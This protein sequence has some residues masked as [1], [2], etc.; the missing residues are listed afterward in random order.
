M[1]I[2]YIA[3]IR[4]P[5]ERAH[6]IQ[7]VHMCNA[8]RNAGNTV[9]LFVTT[10]KT[11]ITLDAEEYYGTRFQF[12]VKPLK[13]PDIIGA[14]RY[15]PS[16]LHPYAY[17]LQRF[18]FTREAARAVK[19][20]DLIYGR[21]EWLVFG[22]S[23]FLPHQR[24]AWESHEAKHNLPARELL[25]RKLL[26]IVIS[27]GIKDAYVKLGYPSWQFLVAHDGIDQSFFEPTETKREARERL[28]LPLDRKIALYIGGL[29]EWK[30]M[31]FLEASVYDSDILFAVIGGDAATIK[32]LK[33]RYSNVLF[34]G[35]RPYRE[36]KDNQQAADVLVIPNTA[37]NLLSFS[38]TSPLKLFAHMTSGVPIVAS[39]IPSIRAILGDQEATFF[40]PDRPIACASAIRNVLRD[41]PTEKAVRAREKSKQYTWDRRADAITRFLLALPP[42]DTGAYAWYD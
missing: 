41:V 37:E 17:M 32:R 13:V 38:Y 21:D 4:F 42:Y 24:I 23:L 29:D 11:D 27:E 3:N 2:A 16:F 25:H 9:D 14:L 8:L 26:T 1:R 35:S 15:I 31:T 5:S 10:R 34:L 20:Y 7:I 28:G 19:G 6:A 22:V 30:G 39:D 40:Q 33:A 12:R 36:L 18:F